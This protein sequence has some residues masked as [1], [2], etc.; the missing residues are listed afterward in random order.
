MYKAC[1]ILV[2]DVVPLNAFE[3]IFGAMLPC[4][5]WWHHFYFC[6]LIVVGASAL[7]AGV[8][9]TSVRD[10]SHTFSRVYLLLFLKGHWTSMTPFWMTFY[11]W[12]E[13]NPIPNY[14]ADSA[15][16]FLFHK[17]FCEQYHPQSVFRPLNCASI[18]DGFEKQKMLK[19]FT[20]LPNKVKL[21]GKIQLFWWKSGMMLCYPCP[22]P[23]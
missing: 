9:S 23:L 14:S 18:K 7:Y 22:M 6:S 10:Y 16:A 13:N 12:R 3:I 1:S 17:V 20:F 5:L 8:G 19:I 2:W 11:R 15:N 21:E 4:V